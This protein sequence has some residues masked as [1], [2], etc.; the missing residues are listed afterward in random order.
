M[1]DITGFVRE[2]VTGRRWRRM[3]KV[4]RIEAREPSFVPKKRVAAYARVSKETDGLL[5]SLSAQVSHYSA[6]IQKNPEWVFAGVYADTG[7]TG[8]ST[9]K[10]DEFRRMIADCNEG[11]IDIVLVKSISRFARNTVDTLD[12]VRHLKDI[13]V[14]VRFERERINSFSGDGEL[15]LSILASF[16]QE[17]SRSL[18]ENIKWTLR[19]GYAEGKHYIKKRM[20]GYR[21]EGDELVIIPE[22]AGTVRYI[23]EEYVKG[24]GI[25]EIRDMLKAQGR[26]GI[27]GNPLRPE[28]IRAVLKNEN[29]TGALVMQKNYNTSPGRQRVNRGELPMYR[30]EEHHEAIIPRELFEESLKCREDRYR[31][32][33]ERV[34]RGETC[35]TGRIRCGKCGS[36]FSNH[37]HYKKDGSPYWTFSCNTRG[38]HGK[39]ACDCPGF[40]LKKLEKATAEVLGT[41]EFEEEF[42]EKVREIRM[43]DRHLEF[44]FK[45]GRVAKWQKG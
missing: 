44:V 26:M 18:S 13:G 30:I 43:Y 7:I 31:A 42:R 15:M 5:H 27:N 25:A 14:E 38:C 40:G 36:G 45:D 6:L 9:K 28:S 35:F 23:F 41:E 34:K 8:T 12:T 2:Y 11:K 24:T 29:Y 1:L 22:E 20:L 37:V 33:L 19:K 39:A 4:R 17:E 10:R 21:W 3:P 32:S 16:A